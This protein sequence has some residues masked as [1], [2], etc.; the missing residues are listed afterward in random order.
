MVSKKS[1]AYIAAV[2]L[3]FTGLDIFAR[4]SLRGHDAFFP[5]ILNHWFVIWL[6]GQAIVAPFQIRLITKHGLGRGVALMN[7]CSV[8]FALI[9]GQVL[10]REQISVQ[11]CIAAALVIVAVWLM[12]NPKKSPQPQ[13]VVQPQ[14]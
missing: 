6:V 4:N 1:L 5:A 2:Q 8:L 9:G 10:L 11:Q 13:S 3:A 12:M 7:A 14:S